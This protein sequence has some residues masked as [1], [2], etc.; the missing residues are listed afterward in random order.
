[1][2]R[3]WPIFAR[4]FISYISQPSHWDKALLAAAG[5]YGA[6]LALWELGHATEL[7]A[8]IL[9]NELSLDLRRTLA[10]GLL[11]GAAAGLILWIVL[12]IVISRRVAGERRWDQAARL[13]S[14]GVVLPVLPILALPG[15]GARAPFFTLALV[16]SAAAVVGIVVRSLKSD[17][18]ADDPAAPALVASQ[19]TVESPAWPSKKLDRIGLALTIGLAAAYTLFMAGLSIARHDAYLTNAFDLGIHDQA[20]Y[21][22]LHS[23]YM[24]ST[25]YGTYAIDY[26]GD[27]FSPILY[28]LA[29][30]YALRE[31]ARTLLA[32][33]SLF[34]AAAAI[35][36]YLL[37]RL[38]TRSVWIALALVMAY[39]LHPALHGV[40]LDDF[41]QLALVI[42]F[43]LS[44]LYFLETERLV[45][46]VICLILALFV[47]EEVALT[48]VAIGAYVFFA[49]RHRRLGAALV[50]GGLLYFGAVIGWVMPRLGGTP[51]IDTR[52]GGYI[53]AGTRGAPGVAWTLF[54][55]PVF[56]AVQV[57][58]N[59]EK[60]TFLLQVFLP[61]LF[62]PLLA[63][64]VAWLVALPALAIQTITNAHTQYDIIGHYTAHLLPLIFFLTILALGRLNAAT[65]RGKVIRGAVTLGLAASTLSMSYLY[66][67]ALP[68]GQT[69]QPWPQEDSHNRVVDS[70]VAQLPRQAVVS[71]LGGIAPHLTA[72]KTIYL[73]PDVGDA[74]YLLL[75]TDLSANYWPYEGLKARDRSLASMTEQVRS[76]AIGLVRAED[77]VFLFQ[78]G[79]DVRDNEA[80]LRQMLST[81]YEAEA[82]RS[83]FDGSVTEDAEASGGKA[84][85]VTPQDRREDGKA[86]VIYGPYTDLQPGNYRATFVVKAQGVPPDARALTVDVFTHNDGYP[87]AVRE[88]YGRDFGTPAAYRAFSLDFNTS[89]QPLEDV[90]FRAVYDFVGEVWID[91]VELW[92]LG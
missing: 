65:T 77:G 27:H 20:I 40:N 23:G 66:S 9:K 21:N 8:F 62:L 55:N 32:L 16:V 74:E 34:L 35:P 2:P 15:I 83:D 11:A 14:L 18:P 69:A 54:T 37:A 51:Q 30:I 17:N 86:T 87:R 4:E 36:L 88:L 70:F 49:K 48:V 78:R 43:L 1:M 28:L 72:R 24:R 47:K 33:Q 79:R 84:R 59:P 73:F 45:P 81:R 63:S 25:L 82:L 92:Y 80:A 61:V 7:E 46:F 75:D 39:L 64:P 50:L 26:I 3:R 12:G 57:L 31:D 58:G 13:L 38:K 42:L 67:R 19:S 56:T 53:A 10:I 41:H 89:G 85:R 71:T 6:A 52:Y 90:E 60:V 91:R 5:G 68:G 22:I 29:P 76:G 44:A